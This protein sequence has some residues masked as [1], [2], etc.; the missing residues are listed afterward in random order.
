MIKLLA[1]GCGGFLG[2]ISRYLISSWVVRFSGQAFP[3]GTLVVNVLGCFIIGCLMQ[4]A[5]LREW[6]S[7]EMRLV[8]IVGFLGS[9]TTFSTFG[10]ETLALLEKGDLRGVFLSVGLNLILGLGAVVMGRQL[11]VS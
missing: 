3:W 8:W 9:L 1:V 5:V 7:P 10:F 6:F 4:L 11:I 2:A